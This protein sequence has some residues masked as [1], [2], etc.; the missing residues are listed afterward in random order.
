MRANVAE[1]H[2]ANPRLSCRAL[3]ERFGMSSRVVTDALR[4]PSGTWRAML[5]LV[6]SIFRYY[7]KIKSEISLTIASRKKTWLY[8]WKDHMMY[9]SR[10]T[11]SHAG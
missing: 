1:A 5:G 9:Q 8:L 10:I 11:S 2:E 3:L 4:K 7:F 6:L